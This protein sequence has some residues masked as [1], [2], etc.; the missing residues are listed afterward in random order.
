MSLEHLKEKTLFALFGSRKHTGISGLNTSLALYYYQLQP[1]EQHAGVVTRW[2]KEGEE[3]GG[4]VAGM[5]NRLSRT[6]WWISYKFAG[7]AGRVDV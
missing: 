3:G 7:L 2:R 5:R 4:A 6:L 1:P